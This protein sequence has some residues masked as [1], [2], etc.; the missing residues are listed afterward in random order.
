MYSDNGKISVRQLQILLILDI[1][2]VSVIVLPRYNALGLGSMGFLLAIGGGLFALV[3]VFLM[4]SLS[5]FLNAYGFFG[6]VSRL[7][8]KPLSRLISAGLVVKL[9]YSL[10]SD[11]RIFS[12]AA[13]LW[14]LPET[15]LVIISAVTL[16]PCLYGAAKGYEAR[17]RLGEIAVFTVLIPLALVYIPLLFKIDYSSLDMN[18]SADKNIYIKGSLCNC[19]MFSGLE[20]LMLSFPYLKKPYNVKPAA[21]SAVIFAVFVVAL[22]SFAAINLLGADLAAELDFPG[23]EAM[24]VSVVSKGKGAILMSF[25]YLSVVMFAIGSIFFS[26]ELLRD[27]TGLNPK[28]GRCLAALFGFALSLIPRNMTEL[29]KVTLCFNLFF[30]GAYFFV[31]PVI[32]N[33]LLRFKR[34][35]YEEYDE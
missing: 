15:P 2:G 31:I 33:L 35:E 34:E 6:G 24:D 12:E 11:L 16:L 28:L 5:G 30:G 14:L 25:F 26:G 20:F 4:C 13:K 19:L 29:S 18:I 23:V 1:L 27:I 9:C 10:G 32:L 7:T 21:V 17:A 22:V 8:G 3:S